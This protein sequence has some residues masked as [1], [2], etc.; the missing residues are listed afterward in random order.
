[1]NKIWY[2]FTQ[3]KTNRE[4]LKVRAGK[5]ALL[6]LE[7][8]RELIDGISSWWVNVLGHAHPGIAKAI[9]E[10]ALKLEHV[11]FAGFTHDPAEQVAEKVTSL[12]PAHLK[13]VFFSDNG[14]TAVEVALKMAYQYWINRGE[15][16][17][18]FICFGGSYHGDTIGAMSLGERS[19][20]NRLFDSLLFSVDFVPY[21]STFPRD[22]E[23]DAKE[24]RILALIE[25]KL[26]IDPK[27]AVVIEPLVQGVGGM[28]MCRPQFLQ[29]LQN[30]VH[31]YDTLLIYDEVMTG[32]GRTG[33]WFACVKSC[34]QP[35]IVCLAK[36]LTGGFLP[37]ALTV[38][39][40][41]I[42]DAFYSEDACKTFYHG[43]SYTA[44]P[45]GC[46]AACAT[47]DLLKENPECFRGMEGR[48]KRFLSEL[49]QHPMLKRVRTCGTIVAMDISTEQDDG[50]LNKIGKAFKEQCLDKGV[51][52]RP[53]GNVVYLM[54]PYCITDEQLA[55][56]YDAISSTLEGLS[57]AG[58]SPSK[59]KSC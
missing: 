42:F 9:Y 1:M 18:T 52:I 25:E 59:S 22:E 26:S 10:Q 6:Q 31:A 32:F 5:G 23:I 21:P 54:P 16:R 7:D 19:L 36:G 58:L 4:P 12:L 49:S 44:N 47:I 46:A 39:S 43:H 24:Q 17:S 38:C 13:R 3:M 50:Y 15:K 48:H 28:Q 51:L 37:L 45:L 34:T 29:K 8:G 20:F 33:E 55:I 2:P 40:E 14:S 57:A 35:D 56:A 30:L 41:E 27:I 11:I 53:L